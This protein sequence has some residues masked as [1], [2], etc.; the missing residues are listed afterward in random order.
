MIRL[1]ARFITDVNI[2]KRTCVEHDVSCEFSN[3]VSAA[4]SGDV[5]GGEYQKLLK[6]PNL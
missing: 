5:A 6:L 4:R 2:V 1:Y 3:E